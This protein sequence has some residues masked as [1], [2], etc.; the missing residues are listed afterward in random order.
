MRDSGDFWADLSHDYAGEARTQALGMMR[1]ATMETWPFL[2]AATDINDLDQRIAMVSERVA[3][4]AAEIVRARLLTEDECRQAFRESVQRDWLALTAGSAFPGPHDTV[5]YNEAGEPMGWDAPYEPDP[6][7]M[8]DDDFGADAKAAHDEGLYEDAIEA[9]QNGGADYSEAERFAEWYLKDERDRRRSYDDEDY[10]PEPVEPDH[11]ANSYDYWVQ[12]GRPS[13]VASKH[14]AEQWPASHM[15]TDTCKGCGKQIRYH[16]GSRKW[17]HVNS[18]DAA[19]CSM[20]A[21][22]STK[23]FHEGSRRIAEN[24]AY[25]NGQCPACGWGLDDDGHC[26]NEDCSNWG[27]HIDESHR[28]SKTAAAEYIEIGNQ[29]IRT[30]KCPECGCTGH[31]GP[32]TG[33]KGIL[34][35]PDSFKKCNCTFSVPD[36]EEGEHGARRAS[37]IAVDDSMVALLNT[38]QGMVN[39]AIQSG[40]YDSARKVLLGKTVEAAGR[41]GT[42]VA[43]SEHP[44]VKPLPVGYGYGIILGSLTAGAKCW[45]GRPAT[46]KGYDYDTT[47]EV[48][49]CDRHSYSGTEEFYKPIA[50]DLGHEGARRTAGDAPPWAKDKKKSDDKSEKKDKPQFGKGKE[51][52]SDA[53][54]ASDE[55]DGDEHPPEDEPPPGAASPDA[56][57]DASVDPGLSD[58]GPAGSPVGLTHWG[59]D[60]E[61]AE[62]WVAGTDPDGSYIEIHNA[63]PDML[64]DDLAQHGFEQAE[65]DDAIAKAMEFEGAGAPEDPAM[66]EN[67]RPVQQ[68]QHPL[69]GEV[70]GDVR[71]PPGVP[72]QNS[73]ARTS[74]SRR[75]A[76]VKQVFYTADIIEADSDATER[77]EP[78]E[79]GWWDPDWTHWE[80]QDDKS[81]VKPD[82]YDPED[83]EDP[84]AWLAEQVSNRLGVI[85]GADGSGTWYSADDEQN[86]QTGQSVRPA[87]HAEGFTDEE[88]ARAEDIMMGKTASRRTAS[89][90]VY[91]GYG[92]VAAGPFES[93]DIARQEL[94]RLESKPGMADE[95]YFI[96]NEQEHHASRR[97]AAGFQV[98][99]RVVCMGD[100]GKE[101]TGTIE[102]SFNAPW[103]YAV[104]ADDDGETYTVSGLKVHEGSRRTAGENIEMPDLGNANLDSDLRSAWDPGDPY[105]SCMLIW[106]AIADLLTSEGQDVPSAWEHSPGLGGPDKDDFYF[107]TLSEGWL[108]GYFAAE[109]LRNAGNILQE[110]AH[111][112]DETGRSY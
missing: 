87:A 86:Y 13:T 91:D 14:G 57:Q 100:D 106:F 43:V 59:F 108:S 45:C 47:K 54:P 81:D 12:Q 109:D 41:R 60:P 27:R 70:E 92:E 56:E 107:Q 51:D 63:D 97:K 20:G 17:N 29:R 94:S 42:I 55:Q 104:R 32:C 48:P 10:G 21:Y 46:G 78:D 3:P 37:K 36:D 53:P 62:Y 8:Y 80:V 6:N 30:D 7:D 84:A 66:A 2:V 38:A 99:D 22:P 77:G 25:P 52:K 40:D 67:Q 82:V 19:N 16:A 72:L 28:G 98:G 71:T 49:T 4:V 65:I 11:A 33:S 111:H 18:D 64:A 79:S 89:F 75:T 76:A 73:T 93:H 35:K 68:S 103:T 23:D 34:G 95:G 110:F 102:Q 61:S 31:E 39:G 58:P 96:G 5:Y 26:T 50:D 74:T 90:V 83:D 9:A 112:L 101:F 88:I 24:P 69:P 1:E 15:G 85:D 44:D 105:G